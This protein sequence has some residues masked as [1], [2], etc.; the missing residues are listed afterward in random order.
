MCVARLEVIV[1]IVV[2]ALTGAI[3]VANSLST[4]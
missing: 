1:V 3:E 2:I 4:F